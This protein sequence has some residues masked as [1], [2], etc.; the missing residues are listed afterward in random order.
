CQVTRV[1]MPPTL[2]IQDPEQILL[3]LF[4]TKFNGNNCSSRSRRYAV[5]RGTTLR[6]HS[7]LSVNPEQMHLECVPYRAHPEGL[8]PSGLPKSNQI[9]HRNPRNLQRIPNL[10]SDL[11]SHKQL[12]GHRWRLDD[13]LRQKSMTS[14]SC[15]TQTSWPAYIH[16]PSLGSPP[17]ACPR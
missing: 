4:N 5:S 2:D 10:R 16:Q 8:V 1:P 17:T 7:S 3:E 9:A 13:Q 14:A 6:E 11:S 15:R 12:L